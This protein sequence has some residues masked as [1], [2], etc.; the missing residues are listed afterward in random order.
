MENNI[1]PVIRDFMRNE[2]IDLSIS[3]DN[4]SEFWLDDIRGEITV[5]F[6]IN[7][8]KHEILYDVYLPEASVHLKEETLKD[9]ENLEFIA[10]ENRSWKI[11]EI[12]ENIW[13]I[14]EQINIW[15]RKN[16]FNVME[17]QLI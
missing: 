12:I 10:E 17:K 8:P 15:A 7:T 9:V 2:K 3:K 5:K 13:L 1:I 16:N 6:K 11:A 14:L 4:S